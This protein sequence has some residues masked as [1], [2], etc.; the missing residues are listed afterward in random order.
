MYL[1]STGQSSGESYFV[2]S[3]DEGR[4]VFLQ[5]TQQLVSQ[6]RDQASDVYD[7]REGGGFSSVVAPPC[8]GEACRPAIS[9]VP[10]IYGAPSSATFQ[11][12][13]NIA[14][15]T[16]ASKAK[17]KRVAKKKHRRRGRAHRRARKAKRARVGMA[18]RL[19]GVRSVGG[20]R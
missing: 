8:A 20:G 6:D 16:P 17:A 7:A 2:D 9:P 13:G 1:I 4:D 14:S 18:R 12:A 11:G 19:S 3:G 5:S 15:S 10:A